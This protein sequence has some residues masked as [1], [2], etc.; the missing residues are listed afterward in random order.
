MCEHLY[1]LTKHLQECIAQDYA[2]N[3]E[4]DVV[5]LRPWDMWWI[6]V[7]GFDPHGKSLDDVAYLRGGVGLCL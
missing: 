4:L 6:P 2:R 5:V 7:P 1:D 3:G